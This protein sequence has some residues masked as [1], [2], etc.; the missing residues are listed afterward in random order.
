MRLK[1]A[2][3]QPAS[4]TK[5]KLLHRYFSRILTANSRKPIFQN[6]SQVNASAEGYSGPCQD[7]AFL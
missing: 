3:C 1:V 5:N 7:G 2:D 6:T 4:F